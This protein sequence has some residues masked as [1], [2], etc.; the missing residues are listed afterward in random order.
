MLVVTCLLI[1]ILR[2]GNVYTILTNSIRLFLTNLRWQLEP[3]I[4]V[5]IHMEMDMEWKWMEMGQ[6][7]SKCYGLVWIW[8][9]AINLKR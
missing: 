6:N 8:G 4:G 1:Q 3:F 9:K 5:E 2:F 7:L